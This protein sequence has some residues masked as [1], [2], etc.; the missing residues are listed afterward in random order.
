MDK[1]FTM[2]PFRDLTLTAEDR[3]KLVEITDAII[4]EK[5][6]E[7]VEHLKCGKKVNLSRWKKFTKTGST[8]S[9]LERKSSS[10]NTKLPQLQMVGPL[11]GSLDEIMFGLVSPTIES[12]RIKTTYLNDFN[13]GAV[14][15]T[16]VEPTVDDPFR[17]VVV[18]WM[19][20]D[21]PL[22]SIGLVRNRDYVYIESTG[23]LFL[24]SGERVGYHLLHSASFP[25]VHKLPNR[26]RGN[27][28][29][30]GI[31][32][33]EVPHRTDCRGTGIIDPGG[34]MIR[35]MAVM[36]M[37]QATMA[38]L[39]YSYCGQ[40]KKLAWLLEQK[41]SAASERGIPAYTPFCVTCTKGV[42][43]SS[44]S[45][46][47]NT[48]KLCFGTLCGSCKIVKKLS[49]I[50]PD[51]SL[52]QR[53]V[54]FCVKCIIEATEMNTQEAAREQFVYKKSVVSPIYGPSVIS[55]ISTCSEGV[56]TST[57]EYVG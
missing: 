3:V 42:K 31:F 6:D 37:A 30:C 5:F 7:Y 36:G 57:T 56:M 52:V 26:V 1:R 20:I 35:A 15:A 38:G 54:T 51:L 41:K 10:P 34:D 48:C 53:K 47:I 22:A 21:I 43:S 39:K 50:A 24:D 40:M 11:P 45:E 18:K 28:S 14:L 23:I 27:M 8:T 33:Q 12:M 4:M 9:Y 49:F 29:F 19:E 2:K 46:F 44:H 13:A 32:H 17:S 16:I 25:E 55:E